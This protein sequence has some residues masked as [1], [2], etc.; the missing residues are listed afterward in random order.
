MARIQGTVRVELQVGT[1]GV[2][3]SARAV[4]GPYQ[5]RAAAEAYA[6]TWRFKAPTENGVPRVSRFTVN[7]IYHIKG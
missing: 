4:D 3:V 5:L 2:P 7:V 6:L 1:D